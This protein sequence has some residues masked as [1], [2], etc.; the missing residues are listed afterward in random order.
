[1]ILAVTSRYDVACEQAESNVRELV[2]ELV[3]ENLISSS[4]DGMPATERKIEQQE[5][6]PYE[7]PKLNIYR[8]MGDLLALDP[9]VPS[10]G[11]TLWKEPE[12]SST[13]ACT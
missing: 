6:V 1:V 13:A 4:E 3:Q 2:Q 9:P 8:D 10:L 5:K 12:D 11:D 7:I